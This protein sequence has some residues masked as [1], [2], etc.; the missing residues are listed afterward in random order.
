MTNFQLFQIIRQLTM[1]ISLDWPPEVLA[2]K[3]REIVVLVHRLEFPE[4]DSLEALL[5]AHAFLE[6]L[7]VLHPHTSN[8]TDKHLLLNHL[9]A[10]E[11]YLL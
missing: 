3:R 5:Q 2:G 8:F 1:E 6:K 10:M 4:Q 9:R 11:L 7:D